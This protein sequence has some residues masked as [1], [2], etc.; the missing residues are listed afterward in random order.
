LKAIVENALGEW[1]SDP[2]T[3]PAA[4][5]KEYVDALRSPLP[6]STPSVRST[7]PLPPSI[8]QAARIIEC[9]VLALWSMGG[10]LDEWYADVGGPLGMLR[11][12]GSN[13]RGWPVRGGHFFPEQNPVYTIAALREFM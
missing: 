11:Q 13:V 6:P 3:F 8:A 9:P 5:P 4:V 1:G 7:A 12:W 2:S 10:P